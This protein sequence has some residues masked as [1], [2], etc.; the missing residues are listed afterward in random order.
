MA[1]DQW[2]YYPNC[3]SEI[4]AV[5][6]DSN[7]S[8][9]FISFLL[10]G[11]IEFIQRALTILEP[12]IGANGLPVTDGKNEIE[13]NP[14]ESFGECQRFI[15]LCKYCRDMKA[16]LQ[17][18]PKCKAFDVEQARRVLSGDRKNFIFEKCPIKLLDA[19]CVIR[20]AKRDVA[21]LLA[22]QF[23]PETDGARDIV[24]RAIR[25]IS[26]CSTIN[27]HK[28]KE[29]LKDTKTISQYLE[30]IKRERKEEFQNETDVMDVIRKAAESIE[31]VAK[32]QYEQRKGQKEGEFHD[33]L[34]PVAQLGVKNRDDLNERVSGWIG[35][36]RNFCGASYVVLYVKDDPFISYPDTTRLLKVLARTGVPENVNIPDFNWRNSGLE[37]RDAHSPAIDQVAIELLKKGLAKQADL[38]DDARFILPME[39]GGTYRGLLVIGPM[40]GMQS[41][42]TS[43]E[44]HFL[45]M[46][47]H[48][49][50]LRTLT[51]LQVLDS[52]KKVESLRDASRLL[53]H[54]FRR[55]LNPVDAAVWV[56]TGENYTEDEV[57][58]AGRRL[59][60]IVER[61]NREISTNIEMITAEREGAY[62]FALC[63]F[64]E[65]I[66]ACTREHADFARKREVSLIANIE[67][68]LTLAADKDKLTIAISNILHNAIK[69]SHDQRGG[70][71]NIRAWS[72]LD[73]IFL[74]IEDFGLGIDSDDKERIFQKGGQG[75]RSTR[76]DGEEGEGLGL[77]QADLIIKAHGGRIDVIGDISGGR[78]EDSNDLEGYK[79]TFAV[80]LPQRQRRRERA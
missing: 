8:K 68:N 15:E 32:A 45:Q 4:F 10:S 50:L 30:E 69:Y 73:N 34:F 36:I 33:N 20:V 47:S 51:E 79:V 35:N 67:P 1:W 38:F 46:V 28:L 70:R 62:S 23:M 56:V 52:E 77:W 61:V 29:Y 63:S 19:A 27:D 80:E 41:C 48:R 53:R 14:I 9:S 74:E 42:D 16:G 59:Q 22:G 25:D 43:R 39:M 21:V 49:V 44:V 57:K 5:E 54:G 78:T 40:I 18:D 64:S 6:G 58:K 13:L 3:L 60:D 31:D 17:I 26:A 37:V 24:E 76:A 75:R 11:A 2:P 72:D 71:V 66:S 65:I 7:D 55:L 12:E